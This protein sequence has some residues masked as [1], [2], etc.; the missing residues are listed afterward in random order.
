MRTTLLFQ[1]DLVL[2]YSFGNIS[3]ET[4]A[5]LRKALKTFGEKKLGRPD[6]RQSGSA[7]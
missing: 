5:E 7:K 2:G 6:G 3:H 4:Q 1:L